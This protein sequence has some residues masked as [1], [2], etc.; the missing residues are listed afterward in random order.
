MSII[1]SGQRY[2]I[3]NEGNGM[4]VDLSGADNRS[5]LGWAFHGGE[6]QQVSNLPYRYRKWPPY[7]HNSLQWILEKQGDGQWTIQSLKYQKYLGFES[8]PKDGT[9]VVGLDRPRLWDIEILPDSE[10]HDNTRV[11]FWVRST[12]LVVEFPKERSELGPLQLWA[13]RD[14][15]HQVWVLEE[16][17]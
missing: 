5:I 1:K 15:R 4:V 17:F 2:K 6:N 12:L 16:H 10:D 14:G 9:P 8:T 7:T 3:T 13:A 11:K